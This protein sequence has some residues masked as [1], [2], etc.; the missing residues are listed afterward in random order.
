MYSQ[1]VDN[2][3]PRRKE[4]MPIQEDQ[5]AG[6][7]KQTVSNRK[8]QANRQNASKS[9]GPRTRRGKAFSCRNALKHGLF[10]MDLYRNPNRMGGSGR[11]SKP[12]GPTGGGLSA[13]GSCRG[14]RSTAHRFVLVETLTRVR[15]ENAKIAGKLCARYVEF[16]KVEKIPAEDK[17]RLTL[18]ANARS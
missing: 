1:C 8:V 5:E 13:G 7:E 15:Y 12:P 17:A 2:K 10:A 16:N 11:V 6:S 14:T 3:V 9:T 18:L 4:H